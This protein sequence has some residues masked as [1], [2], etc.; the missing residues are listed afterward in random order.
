MATPKVL[1]LSVTEK[2][3]RTAATVGSGQSSREC[4]AV[5]HELIKDPRTTWDWR[6]STLQLLQISATFTTLQEQNSGK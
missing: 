1:E 2:M 3:K 4:L 6:A 5:A